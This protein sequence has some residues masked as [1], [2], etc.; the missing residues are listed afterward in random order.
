MNAFL[1]AQV[2]HPI[3]CRISKLCRELFCW[4]A[5]GSVVMCDREKCTTYPGCTDLTYNLFAK[6]IAFGRN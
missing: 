2:T 3:L 4:F 1:S 5:A 6:V